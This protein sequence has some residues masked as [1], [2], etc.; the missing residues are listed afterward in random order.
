MRIRVGVAGVAAA[1]ALLV[2]P[3]VSGAYGPSYC[4]ASS[5]SLAAGPNTGQIYFEMPRGTAVSMV[6]W[7]DAQSRRWFKVNSVYGQGYM[8]ATQVARQTS[9]GHC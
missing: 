1:A 8:M 2:S 7:T 9:V 5:C 3:A 6:C 4:S